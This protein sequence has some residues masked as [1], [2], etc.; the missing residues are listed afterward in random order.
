MQITKTAQLEGHKGSIYALEQGPE[1][2]L[3]YSGGGDRLIVEWNLAEHKQS[4]LLVKMPERVFSLR[5]LKGQQLLLAGSY[6]GEIYVLD[7]VDG[8]QL[9]R[10]N[11]HQQM[12]FDLAP[13]PGQNAFIS[14]GGDGVFSVWS[15]EDFSLLYT[16]K[17]GHFKLRNVGFHPNG[18]EM[19]IGS[20]DGCIRIF[21]LKDFGEKQVLEGHF[22]GFS[23]NSLQYIHDGRQMV[24]GSRDAYIVLWDVGEQYSF[25]RRFQPHIYAIYSIV[26]SPDGKLLATGSRDKTIKIWDAATLEL[27]ETIIGSSMEGHTKSVNKIIWGNYRDQLISTGDDRTVKVWGIDQTNG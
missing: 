2:H 24:S 23:V 13:I 1:P 17:V 18:E 12:I 27:K 6:T 5:F 21:D 11:N 22:E 14:L 16:Q 8:K 20:E 26:S 25:N 3:V 4:R 19:A 9:H 7:P 10:L 15:L